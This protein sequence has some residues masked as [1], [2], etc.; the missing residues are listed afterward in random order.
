MPACFKGLHET[1]AH[2]ELVF[3]NMSMFEGDAPRRQCLWW[4]WNACFG[5]YV[6]LDVDNV[7]VVCMV[8]RLQLWHMTMIV[9]RYYS[10]AM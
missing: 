1:Y 9:I 6:V 2:P 7:V 10:R 3:G 4:G 5:E 8:V